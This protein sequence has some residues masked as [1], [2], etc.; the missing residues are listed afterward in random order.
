MYGKPEL[1]DKCIS[2]LLNSPEDFEILVVDDGS[3]APYVNESVHVLRLEKN[4]G[5]TNAVNQGLMSWM[6]SKDYILLLNNDTEPEAGFLQPLVEAM[7]QDASLGIV[8]ASRVQSDKEGYYVENYGLDLIRGHQSVSDY[9][10]PSPIVYCEWVPFCSVLLR[11]KMV[12]EIGL[13]DKRMRT[14]SSDTDYCLRAL[15]NEWRVA[16]VPKSKVVH[17]RSQTVGFNHPDVSPDQK[18]F[19]RKLL[20]VKLNEVLENIPIDCEK[21]NYVQI[22]CLQY[23]KE[24][25]LVKL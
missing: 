1:T 18:T 24:K 17:H 23:E 7:E 22:Q 19:I 9:D 3:E 4:S 8:S 11:S 21:Q 2:C 16:M 13:L 10:L 6:H 25:K 5:F 14:F 12:Y 20:Q 15:V